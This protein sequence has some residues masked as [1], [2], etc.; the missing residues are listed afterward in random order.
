[1]EKAKKKKLPP[2]PPDYSTNKEKYIDTFQSEKK[3]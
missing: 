1:M 3:K 2:L